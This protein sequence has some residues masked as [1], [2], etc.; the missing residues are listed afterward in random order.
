MKA[1]RRDQ[2]KARVEKKRPRRLGLAVLVSAIVIVVV[3]LGYVLLTPAQSSLLGPGGSAP[4]FELPVVDTEGISTANMRLSSLRGKVVLLEFMVSWCE[5]CQEMAPVLE[6]LRYDYEPKGVVFVSIAGT[7][8]GATAETTAEFIR[9]FGTDWTYV[10][11]SDSSVFAKYTV[12]STPT[13]F[14]VGQDGKIVSRLAGIV[15]TNSFV[16]VLDQALSQG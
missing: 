6:S 8:R 10:L 3:I 4:D 9:S 11:D 14:I 12:D 13:F 15:F 5:G 1:K 7:Q 16:S 2:K